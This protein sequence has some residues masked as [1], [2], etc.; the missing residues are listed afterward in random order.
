MQR[1]GKWKV[2]GKKKQWGFKRGGS[3]DILSI[4]HKTGVWFIKINVREGIA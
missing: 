1:G 2:G 4:A 3:H